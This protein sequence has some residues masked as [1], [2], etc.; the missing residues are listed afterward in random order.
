MVHLS[1]YNQDS[2]I[3]RILRACHNSGSDRLLISDSYLTGS[4]CRVLLKI[5]LSYKPKNA[6]LH[7]LI[8][9]NNNNFVSSEKMNN[10]S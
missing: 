2:P 6:N 1:L 10:A 7:F 5:C 3:I 4:L 8:I 9:Y